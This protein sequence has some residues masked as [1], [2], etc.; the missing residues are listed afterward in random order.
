MCGILFRLYRHDNN[1]SAVEHLYPLIKARGPDV[2]ATHAVQHGEW[3]ME[4]TSSVLHLRGSDGPTAQPLR[5]GS[6]DVLCWN[7]E[8]YRGLPTADLA[9][10]ATND[11]ALL[12]ST[13][14]AH[15]RDVAGVMGAVRGEWAMVY[16]EKG[17]GRV[18]FGRDC[19]GRRSLLVRRGGEGGLAL[20]S[21]SN[22]GREW[23]EVKA[24]GLYCIDLESLSASGDIPLTRIPFLPQQPQLP[25]I[26]ASDSSPTASMTLPYPPLN[27]TLPSPNDGADADELNKHTSALHETLIRSLRTRTQTIPDLTLHPDSSSSSGGSSNHPRIAVLFSGGLDCAV[28]ARVLNDV[29]PEGEGVDLV[30]VAFEN[31]RSIQNAKNEKL[32]AAKQ[33][34]KLQLKLDGTVELPLEE[35]EKD[36]DEDWYAHCPDRITGLQGWRELLS[37]TNYTRP[38]RF[39]EVNIPY[40][41]AMSHKPQIVDLIWPNDTV[42]DVSIGMAFYFAARA[43]GRL[44]VW[45]ANGREVVQEEDYVSQARVFL[46]GLGADELFGGYSRHGNAYRTKGWAGLVEEL[47]LDL[48]R[49]PTRNLGRDDR[50]IAHWSR[51]ARYPFLDEEVVSLACSLP[52]HI[53]LCAPPLAAGKE[54]DESGKVVAGEKELLR[55]VARR[56]G[57]MKSGGEKKRAVQFGSRTARMEI[58]EVKGRG[59]GAV[60]VR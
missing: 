57:L 2:F 42:M 48:A 55:R 35:E 30:N 43:H 40:A 16:Y 46:S 4:F 38:Y 45:D 60:K 59:M 15:D 3:V 37:V 8:A 44:K 36:E 11:G 22:G 26:L 19:L 18:W 1:N 21:V 9:E 53:K 10:P 56:V 33:A 31:P 12:L 13:L 17:A 24:D 58:E 47:E 51:E 29:L 52:A 54:T 27:A 49:I 41:E 25:T 39:V 20:S 32:A 23:E 7:G 14:S 28:L 5:S 34:A 6:G 50:V